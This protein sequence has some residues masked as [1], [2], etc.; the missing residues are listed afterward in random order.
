LRVNQNVSALNAHRLL[1]NTG[2]MLNAALEKLSSGMRINRAGDDPSGLA[3][4][5]RLRGQVNGLTRAA[6]NV[7]DG[8][9]LL[10]T[11][12]GALNE[13]QLMLQ[14]LRELAVQ[15]ANGV[16]TANDRGEIQ[17]EV[18]QLVEE[19][20]RTAER[21]EFN[22]RKLLDGTG[23]A[24]WSADNADIRAVIR[25]AVLEGNYRLTR[26]ASPGSNQV[27]KSDI[28]T[29]AAGYLGISLTDAGTT[30][31]TDLVNPESVP[32]GNYT[33]VV[34]AGNAGTGTDALN[35]VGKYQNGGSTSQ[36]TLTGAA[37][38]DIEGE[39]HYLIVEVITGG[40]VSGDDGGGAQIRWSNDNGLTWSNAV[41]VEASGTDT[42][43]TDGTNTYNIQF[44]EGTLNVGDKWLLGA[45]NLDEA[46]DLLTITSPQ[47]GNGAGPT[48]NSMSAGGW[49]D[50]TVTFT[51]GAIDQTSGAVQFGSFAISVGTLADGT[52]TG[53]VT[54]AGGV[55]AASTPL[56]KIALFYDNNGN[57]ILQNPQKLTVWGNNS[58]ADIYLYGSDTIVDLASKIRTAVVSTKAAGGLGMGTEV[59][60][61]DANVVSY[62][63][64]PTAG[65]DESVAG[66][67][68]IR[69]TMPDTQGRLAF[70]GSEELLRALSLAEVQRP[71]DTLMTVVVQN[72]HDLNQ[73]FGPTTGTVVDDNV[74]RGVIQ[75]VEVHID[76]LVDVTVSWDNVT[77]QFTFSSAAGNA[78]ANLHLVDYS[79]VL[80]IGANQG[81]TMV[82]AIGQMDA[83][84]LGISNLLV[85][86][87]TL[88]QEAIAKVDSAINLVSSERAKLGAYMN[89]L[90]H[91]M[92]NLSIQAENL[93]ASES[94]IRDLDMAHEMIKFTRDQIL[95]QAGT[96]MLAQ[97]NA[98]P[99]AVLQLI[100]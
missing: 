1:S 92:A 90:S 78:V 44:T 41:D 82:A 9:S 46:G 31:I 56:Y 52:A 98:V 60:E 13:T 96:A 32:I 50:T 35:I 18:L 63:T 14:R 69:S 10:Q 19:I 3:I 7:Q 64:T 43:F 2:D 62:V 65:T 34:D 58:Y 87:P 4:S 99:Q 97:A 91:L 88:A 47:T 20:D 86:N 66:T 37:D 89:R 76:P 8:T 48:F 59:A 55:A 57:L 61:V 71:T 75:G 94:R 36:L 85:I 84:A 100:R 29:I 70:S 67:L 54:G 6:M 51:V 83:E 39:G 28:F 11:A 30:G 17:K 38:P 42:S 5:E 25:G 73:Y 72:A 22:S 49:D 16:L 26:S 33:I 23:A 80:Q 24:L 45:S 12:E 93:T 21:T 95:L 27:M 74:L 68:V 53:R 81:Q 77:K 15:A 79:V 40:T